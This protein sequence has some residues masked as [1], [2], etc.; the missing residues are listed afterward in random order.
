MLQGSLFPLPSPVTR[1]LCSSPRSPPRVSL[2]NG[3]SRGTGWVGH[4]QGEGG[5][6]EQKGGPGSAAHS[7]PASLILSPI[8]V[9]ERAV[10]PA[11]KQTLKNNFAERQ[12]RLQ[13]VQSRR[14]HRSVL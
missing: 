10:L 9:S 4:L 6:T 3:E 13:V 1:K 2:G 12:K 7:A 14:L 11:L 5:G 8:P